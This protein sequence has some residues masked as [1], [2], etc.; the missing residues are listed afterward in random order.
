MSGTTTVSAWK[1]AQYC[2]QLKIYG[3]TPSGGV[4][5]WSSAVDLSSQ[6]GGTATFEMY[7]INQS[8]SQIS[9]RP[10][11]SIVQNMVNEFLEFDL[12]VHEVAPANGIGNLR[13]LFYN[14]TGV[15]AHTHIKVIA[16]FTLPGGTA[17]YDAAIGVIATLNSGL[18]QGK[19]T[20]TLTAKPCGIAPFAG[21]AGNLPSPYS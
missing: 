9:V 17:Y 12:E 21:I 8:L 18:Q 13:T 10:A 19:N 11:D 5:T 15:Q 6:S 20:D 1:Q 4:I 14:S 16:T 2:T 7:S 3:G